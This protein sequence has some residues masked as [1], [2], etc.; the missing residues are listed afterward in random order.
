MGLTQIINLHPKWRCHFQYNF[1]KIH[2]KIGTLFIRTKV[3]IKIRFCSTITS[4]LSPTELV[5]NIG[6]IINE[7]VEKGHRTFSL[8]VRKKNKRYKFRKK[9]W[10]SIRTFSL[11]LSNG[12]KTWYVQFNVMQLFK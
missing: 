2:S 3:P 1:H 12:K 10:C 4:V 6:S 7:K 9:P 5:C 8:L 11:V